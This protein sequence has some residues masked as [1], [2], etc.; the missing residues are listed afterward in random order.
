MFAPADGGQPAAALAALSLGDRFGRIY[1]NPYD[2]PDIKGVRLDFDLV[3]ER[4]WARLEAA[5]TDMTEARPGDDIVVETVLRPYRGERMVK[6]IPIH[7]PTSASKGPLRILVSD[8]ETLDRM[9]HAMPVFGRKLGLAATIAVLNKEHANNRV[10]VSLLEADPEAM[11]ADKVMPTLPLS[12]MNVMEGMRGTQE[13]VVLGE[14]SV[15]EASTPPL[16]YAVAGGQL[17]TLTIR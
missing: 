9:R 7:I 6:Q 12:I 5:R 2:A 10:Y 17:L 13:M 15:N 1:E 16:D 8:G 3:K 11:V 14:S 4:R